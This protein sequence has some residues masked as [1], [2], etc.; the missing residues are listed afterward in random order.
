MSLIGSMLGLLL[1]PMK[2]KPPTKRGGEL[3]EEVE[4]AT[5]A[6]DY[7]RNAWHVL[8]AENERLKVERDNYRDLAD[9]WRRSYASVRREQLS[10]LS[11]QV[12]HQQSYQGLVQNAAMAQQQAPQHQAQFAQYAQTM[13]YC[14]CAPSRGEAFGN[15]LGNSHGR[16]T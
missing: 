9:Q 13:P 10:Q 12:L 16:A 15:V 1:V 2:A 7:W 14:N 5:F 8:W 4:R 3:A 6:L 11:Q